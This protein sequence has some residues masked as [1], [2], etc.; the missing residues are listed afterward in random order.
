M[1]C[2][3]CQCHN[4]LKKKKTKL[5]P[6]NQPKKTQQN[7]TTQVHSLILFPL[8]FFFCHIFIMC[9]SLWKSKFIRNET[10]VFTCRLCDRTCCWAAQ[11]SLPMLISQFTTIGLCSTSCDKLKNASS[12]IAKE[13]NWGC[14]YPSHCCFPVLGASPASALR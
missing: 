5:K 3:F 12:P 7:K 14:A 13:E 8:C 2:A 11:I 4:E 10:W 6:T 9:F 1:H